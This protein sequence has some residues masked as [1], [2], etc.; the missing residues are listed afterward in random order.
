MIY[1]VFPHDENSLLQDFQTYAD[2]QEYGNEAF[3]PNQYEIEV[4][5]GECL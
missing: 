4:T 3:G 1:T 5:S 2:A